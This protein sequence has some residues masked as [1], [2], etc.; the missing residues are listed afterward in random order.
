MMWEHPVMMEQ[1]EENKS[2]PGECEPS[3]QPTEQWKAAVGTEDL[4]PS[5][6]AFVSVVRR[7][8]LKKTITE[9]LI[10]PF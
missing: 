8:S 4:I 5:G 3:H 9:Y 6:K 7:V 1:S 10:F 2:S